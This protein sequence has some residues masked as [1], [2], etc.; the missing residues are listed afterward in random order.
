LCIAKLSLSPDVHKLLLQKIAPTGSPTI[1]ALDQPQE[2]VTLR[3]TALSEGSQEI[4]PLSPRLCCA[5]LLAGNERAGFSQA[6]Q[7]NELYPPRTRWNGTRLS[8]NMIRVDS[9]PGCEPAI[10]FTVTSKTVYRR[11]GG[12]VIGVVD[13]I[14]PFRDRNNVTADNYPGH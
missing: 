14:D 11:G 12:G 13:R 5:L 4:P 8:G 1:P 10:C 2:K 3:F 9:E 6:T 7:H